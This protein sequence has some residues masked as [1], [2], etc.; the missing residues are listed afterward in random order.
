MTDNELIQAGS[1]DEALVIVDSLQSDITNRGSL[2]R[3]QKTV[4]PL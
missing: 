4:P 2:T 1:I 3:N